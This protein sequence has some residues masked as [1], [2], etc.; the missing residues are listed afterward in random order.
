MALQDTRLPAEEEGHGS[1]M[2]PEDPRARVQG[3]AWAIK[4]LEGCMWSI[5]RGIVPIVSGNY[6]SGRREE[7][8]ADGTVAGDIFL[9]IIALF[10]PP[11]PV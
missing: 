4:G 7:K 1:T 8:E 5:N 9:Y 6:G 3:G 11:A 10:I 2:V